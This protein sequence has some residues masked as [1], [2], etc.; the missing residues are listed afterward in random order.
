MSDMNDFNQ[1]VIAEFRANDGVVGGPFEGLPM[2]LL[3]N[4]G[5]KSGLERINPLCCTV[6]GGDVVI[7]AS[8][9]GAPSHPD[10][11]RNIVANP[12]VTVE[13]GTEKYA[14]TA[15]VVSDEAERQ[16]LYDAQVALM[17]QFGEYAK[18]TTRV[19][20]VVRLVRN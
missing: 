5:A 7:I 20:P 18:N 9:G 3:T 19:I 6:D 14:A 16:R 15:Q 11:Y 12:S 8:K 13:F 17:P 1:G 2:M 4:T 10:W